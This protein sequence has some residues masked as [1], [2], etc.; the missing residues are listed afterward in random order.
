[1]TSGIFID[2]IHLLTHQCIVSLLGTKLFPAT[3]SVSSVQLRNQ[4]SPPDA[5][6]LEHIC[7]YLPNNSTVLSQVV[8]GNSWRVP[9]HHFR[10]C[11]YDCRTHRHLHTA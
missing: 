6:D 1:M 9:L 2:I 3:T 11:F 5:S 8:H 4:S 10:F 7:F